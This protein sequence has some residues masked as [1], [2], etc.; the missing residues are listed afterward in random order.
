MEEEK[1]SYYVVI[2]MPVFEDKDLRA[3]EKLLYGLISSLINKDGYCYA[4]NKFIASKLNISEINVSK[5]LKKM[6]QKGY[7]IMVY[8]RDG[9]IIK[10]RKIYIDERLSKMI[11]ATIIKNDNGTIIKND[12]EIYKA[13]KGINKV[14]IK[15]IYKEKF[16]KFWELYPNKKSKEKTI[17][18][19]NNS[20]I[21]D[22][23]YKT[24]MDK[25][26]IFIKLKSWQD[27]KFVPHPST[28]LNQKRW[29]DEID[30]SE[31]LSDDILKLAYGKGKEAK[32]IEIPDYNW[33]DGEEEKE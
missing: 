11:T 2:P 31:I 20:N 1:Q 14:Y 15:E 33:L 3:N 9:A 29:E 4:S 13:I 23:L 5:T 16:D 17:I 21:T 30:P 32:N 25:L 19:F 7:L 10:N 18:W 28:W 26:K 6:E 12:K 24:I 27:I 8:I 22:E